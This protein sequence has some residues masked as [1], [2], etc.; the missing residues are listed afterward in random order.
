MHVLHKCICF[1]I[2]FFTRHWLD[3]WMKELQSVDYRLMHIE[4]LRGRGKPSVYIIQE[5][6]NLQEICHGLGKRQNSFI[7]GKR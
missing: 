5:E 4:R 3:L 7:I 6:K 1:K 2:F